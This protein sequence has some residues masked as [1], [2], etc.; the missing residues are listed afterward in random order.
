M[1]IS[2]GEL[3]G[4]VGE[5]EALV[6]EYPL[7][8]RLHGQLMLVLYRSGRQAEALESY[9]EAR[10]AMVEQLGLEPGPRFRNSSGRSWHKTPRLTRRPERPG[11]RHQR[12]V[13]LVGA[14]G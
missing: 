1:P 7:R 2:R 12:P 9:R 8:E 6:D 14:G 11:H 13:D 5:L 4:L 10:K 3:A